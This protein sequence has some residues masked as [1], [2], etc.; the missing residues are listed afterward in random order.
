[1]VAV[2]MGKDSTMSRTE[3]NDRLAEL[4]AMPY[5]DYLKSPEW[6]ERR[7]QALDWA[8]N[9]CQ[10]CNSPKEPLNVHH[11]TYDRLGAELPAD[12]VVLCK[13]C[14]EKFHEPTP[15]M[16]RPKKSPK[17]D[18]E[19]QWARKAIGELVR[20]LSDLQ[21]HVTKL[22]MWQDKHDAKDKK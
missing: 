14:H 10:L 21:S 4:R 1:M 11:R 13:D 15:E 8:R 12:L 20:Q 18:K 5:V 22:T 6:R 17:P 2:V 19:W 7:K 9:A 3:A 16:E